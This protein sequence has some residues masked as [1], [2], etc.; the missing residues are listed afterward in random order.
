M[1][2]LIAVAVGVLFVILLVVAFKGCLN[3]RKERALKG[4]VTDTNA[5]MEESGQVGQDFFALLNNAG[6]KSDLEYKAQ[7]TSY[8]GAAES[9]Y[10]RAKA[11]D[12]P[13]EMSQAKSAVVLTLELRRNALQVIADNIST[14]LGRENAIE[15][16]TAITDQVQLL[17]ASDAVYAG[18][19]VPDMTSVLE[20]QGL[21][22]NDVT[23]KAADTV[24]FVALPKE[25][26]L[27][28]ATIT[29][30]FAQVTG[31][32]TTAPGIH[33][34][35]ILSARIGNTDLIPGTPVTVDAVN[36]EL[37]VSVQNGGESEESNVTVTA[38]IGGTTLEAAIPT[39]GAGETTVVKIQITP[40]PPSGE[41]ATVDLTVAPV[42][43][44]TNTDNNSATYTVTFQ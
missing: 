22:G 39:I 13:G 7:I 1:R 24:A 28:P 26:W 15:A 19:A 3:A 41:Q 29:A 37:V 25:K 33:G 30:A 36:P 40:L 11:L 4:F 31:G 10:D 23:I 6:G 17:Y 2:R 44:E 35:A 34:V 38:N 27:D 16:Q 32:T 42:P 18:V 12:A 20:D 5:I 14:A 21:S 9:Q 8:R 43:G